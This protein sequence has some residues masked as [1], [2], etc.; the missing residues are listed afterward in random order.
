VQLRLQA[1]ASRDVPVYS[2]AF[3]PTH[4]W[5]SRLSRPG[6]Q[7][8]HRDGFTHPKTVKAGADDPYIR[9]GRTG[10]LHL[11]L[12]THPSTNWAWYSAVFQ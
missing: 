4:R 11:A 7:V 5:M 2:P 12:V 3:T 6:R 8:L 1:S 9:P 10:R